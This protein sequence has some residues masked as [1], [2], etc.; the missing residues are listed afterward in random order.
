ME[1]VFCNQLISKNQ[2]LRGNTLANR[3]LE[4]AHI[5][6]YASAGVISRNKIQSE[7]EK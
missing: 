7:G 6:Q 5:S 4:T 1:N 3:F 2:S